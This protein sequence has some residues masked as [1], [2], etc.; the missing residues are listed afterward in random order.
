MALR[1]TRSKGPRPETKSGGKASAWADPWPQ[2]AQQNRTRRRARTHRFLKAVNLL[3][4]KS[5][6]L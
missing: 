4:S 2:S 1:M 3:L 6:G 5:N